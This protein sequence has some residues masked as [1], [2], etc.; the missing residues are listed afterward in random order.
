MSV[1]SRTIRGMF[2]AYGSYVGGK[3]L[4]LVSLGIL[5]RVLSVKD[6]GLVALG[7]TFMTFLDTVRDLGLGQAL[8]VSKPEE[9]EARAQTVFSWTIVLGAALSALTAAVSPLVSAFFHQGARFAWLLS[10]LGLDFVLRSFGATHYALARKELDYRSRTFAELSE[11][12]TR[13]VSSIAFALLGFGPWSLVLG[14]IIG[15][16]SLDITVWVMVSFRPKLRFSR[17]HLRELVTFGGTLTGVDI[18][19]AIAH[20]M[21]YVFVGRVLG[22]ASLALYTIGY[23]MPEL[24][25]INIAVVAGDVLFPAYALIDH[26]RLHDAFLLALR[27]TAFVVFPVAVGLAILARPMTIVLFSPKYLPS[28]EVM[29]VLVVY[30]V[31]ITLSIPSGTVFKA[32]GQAWILLAMTIPYI[33]LLV[34]ALLLF[35]HDGIVSVAYCMAATQAA[36]LWLTWWIAARRLSVSIPRLLRQLAAPAVAAAGLG[37]VL[38]PIER[39][40]H[41]PWLALAAGTLAGGAVYVGLVWLVGRDMVM[42]LRET[43]FAGR[44]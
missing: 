18:G 8:I 29:Q 44:S 31:V 7:L 6:F 33:V 19:A 20:Q 41:T 42:R 21:D 32:T 24:L 3:L 39:T 35:A 11:V 9:L 38:W 12:V 26:G 2:W 4:L 5:T 1:G 37:A 27:S 28:V 14:Y 34:V 36:F 25:I 22:P 23:R 40:I 10:A 17:A 43:A 30:A 15:V 13:G 16:I